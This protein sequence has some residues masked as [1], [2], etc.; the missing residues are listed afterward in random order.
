MFGLPIP[1]WVGTALFGYKLGL[2]GVR[3]PIVADLL[4]PAGTPQAVQRPPKPQA[5]P[6]PKP[7]DKPDSKGE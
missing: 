5:E 1:I 3:V 4:A 7:V 2:N 6:A